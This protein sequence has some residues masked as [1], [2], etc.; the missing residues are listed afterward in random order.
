M[1]TRYNRRKINAM[2]ERGKRM[3]A[4][5]WKAERERQNAEMPARIRELEEIATQNLP[6]RPGDPLGCLQ[7]HDFRTG[8]V[9][10]WIVRIGDRRDRVT[11]ETTGGQPTA[12]HGWTWL[13]E[14]IRAHLCRPA[15]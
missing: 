11:V 10:R 3:A 4:A 7:W 12:S 5:R 13:T 1:L 8:R 9:R 15:P 6:H 2:R 14:K